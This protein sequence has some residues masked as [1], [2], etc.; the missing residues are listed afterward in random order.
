[1]C[2]LISFFQKKR[3]LLTKQKRD[4]LLILLFISYIFYK[5]A[6]NCLS[7]FNNLVV[8]IVIEFILIGLREIFDHLGIFFYLDLYQVI[9][10][11]K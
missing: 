3:T 5:S 9:K 10:S 2:S 6:F 11:I 1:M 8:I 7:S 4:S